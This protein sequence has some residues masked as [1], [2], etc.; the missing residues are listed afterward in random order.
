MERLEGKNPNPQI[1]TWIPTKR[2]DIKTKTLKSD[3]KEKT[4]KLNASNYIFII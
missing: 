2:V 1:E 4:H 3:I